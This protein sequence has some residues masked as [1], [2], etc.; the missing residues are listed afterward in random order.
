[1]CLFVCLLDLLQL[2]CVCIVIRV[3]NLVALVL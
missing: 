3:V 2:L 1:M